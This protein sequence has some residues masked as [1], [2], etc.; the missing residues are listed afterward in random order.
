MAG[1]TGGYKGLNISSHYIVQPDSQ[2]DNKS[3]A[4]KK[5]T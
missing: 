5:S 1:E 3:Q 4:R 2:T